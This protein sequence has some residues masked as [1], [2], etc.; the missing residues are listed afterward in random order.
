MSDTLDEALGR[1]HLTDVEY[2]SG[3]VDGLSNHG[4]MAAESLIKLGGEARVPSFVEQYSRRLRPLPALDGHPPVLGDPSTTAA[5][6]ARYERTLSVADPRDALRATLDELLPV[7]VS[8]AAHGLL[9]TAHAV[10]AWL[11]R[12]VPVRRREVAFAL[13]SWAVR[14]QTIPGTP[15]A[16]P[17]RGLDVVSALARVPLLP[18]DDRIDAGLIVDRVAQVAA[19][20]GFAATVGAVDLDAQPI[21]VAITSLAAAAARLF[22]RTPDARF[23]YLHALTGTSS[24]RMLAPLLDAPAQRRALGAV[25]HAVAA[26]HS[27]YGDAAAI[28]TLDAPIEPSTSLD[29]ETL[30]ARALASDDDHDVKMIA[31]A[32][33]EH[34]IDPRPEFLAAAS[35][36]V[37]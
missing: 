9:R 37:S 25:F 3:G 31:A 32:L 19:V 1:L 2:A 11:A 22:V 18:T 10:R 20:P 36:R 21:D 29:R 23:V 15:G 12:D 33:R 30:R 26:L 17:T 34:A 6:I 35:I 4:P 7:A 13:A 28:A 14:Y 5:W 27:T 24:L 16:T 8:G